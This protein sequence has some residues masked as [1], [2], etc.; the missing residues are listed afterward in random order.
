M[1]GNV[2]SNDASFHIWINKGIFNDVIY[3]S[4]RGFGHMC[5]LIYDGNQSIFKSSNYD[6]FYIV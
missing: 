3:G 6:L 5:W 1:V 4:G 2:R